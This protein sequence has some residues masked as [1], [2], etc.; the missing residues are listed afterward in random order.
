MNFLKSIGIDFKECADKGINL[1]VIRIELDYK[2]SLTSGDS[3]TV[4]LRSNFESRLKVAFHQDIFDAE[5]RLV[6]RGKVLATALNN[7]GRPEIPDFLR[8]SIEKIECSRK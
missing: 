4:K 5:N 3:F 7:R 8:A 2:K 6:I 1:V